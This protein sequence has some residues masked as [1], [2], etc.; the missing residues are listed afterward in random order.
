MRTGLL[1]AFPAINLYALSEA[2]PDLGR[3]TK[4]QLEK[5]M[6][7]KIVARAEIVGAYQR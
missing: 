4:G 7:R 1:L 6:Q 2:L 5:A 3:P